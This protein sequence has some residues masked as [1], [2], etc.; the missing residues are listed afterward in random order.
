MNYYKIKKKN[1]VREAFYFAVDT[2]TVSHGPIVT[3][4]PNVVWSSNPT[5]QVR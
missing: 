5:L 2:I 4:A 1:C 3:Y